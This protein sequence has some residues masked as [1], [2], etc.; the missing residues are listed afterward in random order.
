MK[1]SFWLKL[2]VLMFAF[3]FVVNV[4]GTAD[5]GRKTRDLVFEDEEDQKPAKTETDKK[6]E[7]SQSVVSV[8]ATIELNRNGEVT[9][10]LPSHEFQS[11]DKVKIIYTTNI[12]CFVYWMSEG[13]SGDH[14]MLFPNA[15]A[16]TDNWVKKNA[17]NT[18]PIKGVFKFDE[19]KGTEKILLV[20]APE[21]IPELDE[22]SKQAMIKGGTV[23]ALEEKQDSGRKTRDLVFEEEDNGESGVT[24]KSQKS[25]DIKQ[26]FV[27][28]F[29]L[30]HN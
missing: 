19:N 1:H 13:S 15:K 25:G 7:E 2:V 24:T 20:M 16:G 18:I 30:V 17:E 11:G 21:R 26:P 10:V 23:K 14:F 27:V 28:A 9:Q 4:A 29:E 3:A 8:K 6:P 22:A 12:D 5:A